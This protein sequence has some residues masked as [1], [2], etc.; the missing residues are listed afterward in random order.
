MG[1]FMREGARQRERQYYK[2]SSL[3]HVCA[4]GVPGTPDQI[5]YSSELRLRKL[6]TFY[7]IRFDRYYMPF[8]SRISAKL[9]F[10]N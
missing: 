9:L 6:L 4:E 8:F 1:F 5:A 10:K 7:S 3:A 2:R